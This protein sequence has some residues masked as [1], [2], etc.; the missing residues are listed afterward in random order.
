MDTVPVCSDGDAN[1]GAGGAFTRQKDTTRRGPCDHTVSG[2]VVKSYPECGEGS[3][4]YRPD[5][6]EITGGGWSD[7]DADVRA[8]ANWERSNRRASSDSRRYFVRNSLRYMWVLTYR[9]SGLHDVAG[10]QQAMTDVA[11]FV[12]RLRSY[13]GDKDFC[14][15]AS[16]ELHPGGHGWHVNFFVADRLPH[17]EIERIWGRGFVWAEDFMKGRAGTKRQRLRAAATYGCKYAGKDW[18]R[19]MLQPG[20][21]RYTAAEGYSPAFVSRSVTSRWAGF[22]ELVALAD[23]EMPAVH[24]RSEDC[25]S[26]EGPPWDW[27]AW[28]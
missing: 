6:D 10:R 16:P 4:G 3:V 27:L 18:S 11:S 21:R 19:E 5:P 9:G 26:Y 1:G 25:S 22:C 20:T 8:A 14:Y 23:G 13:L 2:F 15:W 12:R 28:S 24:V 17:A 7:L